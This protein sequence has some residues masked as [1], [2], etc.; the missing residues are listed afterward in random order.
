[1]VDVNADT[2]NQIESI[3]HSSRLRVS[4]EIEDILN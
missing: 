2:V 4:P 1:M 3:L